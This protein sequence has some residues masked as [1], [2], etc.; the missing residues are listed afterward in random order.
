LT[1]SPS[2]PLPSTY[3][4]NTSALEV[5]ST[6]STSVTA[7]SGVYVIN[8]SCV[9]VSGQRQRLPTSVVV[10]VDSEPPTCSLATLP[11]FTSVSK[12][13]LRV[14]ASDAL[15]APVLSTVVTAD[16]RAVSA[17]AAE[18]SVAVV[19]TGLS[20]GS[21]AWC[22]VCVD[23]AGNVASPSQLVSVTVDA[24][25]P[26]VWLPSPPPRYS[27]NATAVTVC[28]SDASP[29]TIV[30]SLNDD[31]VVTSVSGG[32]VCVNVTVVVDGSYVLTVGGS[33]AAGNAAAN[34]A[35]AFALDRT[36]P[37]CSYPTPPP[38][39][40]SN[41]SVSLPLSFSDALSP[42]SLSERVDGGAQSRRDRVVCSRA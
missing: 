28:R 32:D 10:T 12:V 22:I 37:L 31:V 26:M 19:T 2:L 25:R 39:F 40:V 36:P 29:S 38:P 5:S 24:V 15:S 18:S 14:S 7:S 1:S 3:A 21:H 34:V 13:T 41:G 27:V 20:D 11:S 23:G 42:V 30:A 4:L 33:D 17:S 8:V 16:G 9:D 35:V 6:V